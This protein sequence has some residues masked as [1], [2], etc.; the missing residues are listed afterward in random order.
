MIDKA[1]QSVAK[2]KKVAKQQFKAPA[3]IVPPANLSSKALIV[4]VIIMSFLACLTLGFVTLIQETSKTWQNQ[5]S[6]EIT[7]QIKPEEGRDMEIAL[8]DAK[9]LAL[10]FSGT[11]S[12]EIVDKTDTARL[13]EP[14]LGEGFNMDELPVPRLLII[15]IDKDNP[16]DFDSMRKTLAETIP[17]AYLDDHR[18]WVGRLVSMA[19]NTVFIGVG[20]L[21]LVLVATT[22][23]VVFATRG[24]MSVNH[25]IIEVLHF[26]GAESSFV[27]NEFQKHFLLTGFYGGAIGGGLA[28]FVFFITDI[29]QGAS[30]ATA[31]NDQASALFGSFSMGPAG[32]LGI[33]III[34]TVAILTAL[35]TRITVIK[36]IREIDIV[37]SDP[38]RSD[39]A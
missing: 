3:P 14:W 20:L 2:V 11:L 37:R 28:A 7:I 29:W 8:L 19:Q 17:N 21:S 9:S 23:T 35:T 34:V 38:A 24:A 36:T 30:M 13:L 12:A 31:L 22:L 39:L 16:P 6:E 32:Y 27:A 25:E 4:V 10:E 26:V 15:T 5:I 18:T 33:A 1:K